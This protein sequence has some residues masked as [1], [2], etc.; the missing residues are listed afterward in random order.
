MESNARMNNC[1]TECF[2]SAW[3]VRFAFIALVVCLSACSRSSVVDGL[4]Q[5]EANE[6]VT[7]LYNYGVKASVAASAAVRGK[8]EVSVDSSYASQ[9]RILLQANDLP[10]EPAKQLNDLLEAKGLLPNPREVEQARVDLALSEEVRGLIEKLP[11][12]RSASVVVRSML[13]LG[14]SPAAVIVVQRD[15]SST[16]EDQKF[17]TQIRETVQ[18]VIASVAPENIHIRSVSV[19][20]EAL[21]AAEEIFPNEGLKLGVPLTSFLRWWKIPSGEVKSLYF[22]LIIASVLSLVV[23]GFLGYWYG[24]LRQSQDF[25]EGETE[26]V[27]NYNS[28]MS[29]AVRIV[30]RTNNNNSK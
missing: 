30:G 20:A 25:F 18:P 28:P 12:V 5:R 26:R 24:F 4:S 29:Q 10:R 6:V 16:T 21:K 14:K 23:G 19:S 22:L 2:H 11:E 9:A 8:Y 17:L 3:L 1:R 15:A 27:S 13:L 7:V